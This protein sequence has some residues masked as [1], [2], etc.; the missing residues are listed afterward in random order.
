MLRAIL[1]AML[2][3]KLLVL[4]LPM[5]LPILLAMLPAMLQD[6]EDFIKGPVSGFLAANVGQQNLKESPSPCFLGF[7]LRILSPLKNTICLKDVGYLL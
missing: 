4:L 3:A 6:N 1:I 2:I 5:L 7:S